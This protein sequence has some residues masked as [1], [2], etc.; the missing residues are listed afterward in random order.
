MTL[1]DEIR[2]ACEGLETEDLLRYL[3]QERFP[4][5]TVVTASL[6]AP[7]IVVLSLVAAIAP[8][9]PIVF[10]RPGD[11]FDESRAFRDRL[12]KRL[13]LTNVGE[14]AG[15]EAGILPDA[16]DHYE[17]MWAE[18]KSGLG[19][20]HEMVHLNDVLAD[21]DC[22]IGAVYHF[23]A[24]QTRLRVDQEGRLIRVDP[25]IDWPPHDVR[26]YMRKHD[27]QFHP[28]AGKRVDPRLPHDTPCPPTYH[29]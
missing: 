18:Y 28:R 15:G 2:K 22:W 5:R 26:A 10:C 12:I 16:A 14:T 20:V 6:R 4:G 3:I 21:Y 7:S 19:H 9:T 1:Y 13:G 29:F 8:E 25:L 27:L 11:L 24:P 23:T 17:R